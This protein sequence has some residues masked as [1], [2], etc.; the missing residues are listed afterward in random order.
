M[1]QFIESV[2]PYIL[3][4]IEVGDKLTQLSNEYTDLHPLCSWLLSNINKSTTWCT[5]LASSLQQ[6]LTTTSFTDVIVIWKV[7]EILSVLLQNQTTKRKV[8]ISSLQNILISLVSKLQEKDLRV[9]SDD[10]DIDV[11]YLKSNANDLLKLSYKTSQ[12]VN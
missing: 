1:D 12:V 4:N 10:I 5:S 3:N 2:I 11:D 6:L 9:T 8:D 7:L